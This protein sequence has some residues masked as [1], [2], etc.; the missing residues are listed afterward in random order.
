MELAFQKV[1][2]PHSLKQRTKRKDV[3]ST[4]EFTFL[5]VRTEEDSFNK[6]LT[7]KHILCTLAPLSVFPGPVTLT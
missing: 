7:A 4:G 3:S 6:H 1:E 5:G 2:I